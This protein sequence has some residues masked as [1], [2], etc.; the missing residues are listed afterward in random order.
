MYRKTYQNEKI[1]I[2]AE[3][4]NDSPLI[5][6][7]ECFYIDDSGC[8]KSLVMPKAFKIRDNRIFY[9]YRLNTY[10]NRIIRIIC[11]GNV[12]FRDLKRF[13]PTVFDYNEI[14]KINEKE[15]INKNYDQIIE[16]TKGIINKDEVESILNKK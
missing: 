4:E 9:K 7:D 15:F 3:L 11:K 5:S 8:E 16:L 10:N 13:L 6:F 2:E 12:N 1:S 14:R